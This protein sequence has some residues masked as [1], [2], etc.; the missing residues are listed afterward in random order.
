[1]FSLSAN[2][3]VSS[4]FHV[5]L[6]MRWIFVRPLGYLHNLLDTLDPQPIDPRPTLDCQVYLR[7]PR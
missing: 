3:V 4:G 6:K 7:L 5:C 1:M 2:C